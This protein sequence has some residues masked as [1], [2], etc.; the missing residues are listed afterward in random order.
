[1]AAAALPSTTVNHRSLGFKGVAEARFRRDLVQG[2]L[3][4]LEVPMDAIVV[5]HDAMFSCFVSSKIWEICE[6]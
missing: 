4:A 1:M 6:G 2:F 5:L 3:D